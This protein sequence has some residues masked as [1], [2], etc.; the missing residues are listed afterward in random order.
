MHVCF[1]E[2]ARVDTCPKLFGIVGGLPMFDQLIESS[3]YRE[4]R[5]RSLVYVSLIIHLTILGILIV[6][7]LVYY[8]ALPMY[9][10][11]AKEEFLTA[12]VAPPLPK[13]EAFVRQQPV[14]VVK[15]DPAQF[16]APSEIPKEIPVPLDDI[17]EVSALNGIIGGNSEGIAGI[18]SGGIPAGLVWEG[19]SAPP[20]EAPVPVPQLT[21][22]KPIR[23]GGNV[24][25]SRLIHR[26]EPEYPELAKRTRVS[27]MVILEVIVS[28]AGTVEDV[29]VIRGHPL[30][31]EAA[32]RAVR[33]WKYSPYFL[34]GEPI[35]VTATV[36]V[37][38]VLR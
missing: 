22:K 36:T 24:Q 12:I 23:V 30:L 6:V 7:P 14:Q 1:T 3:T 9:R 26:V 16:V 37:K 33:Q 19:I 20:T 38:F 34:N 4:S 31:N 5:G 25:A 32:I 18:F 17:P 13:P 2:E 15:L 27:G 11:A 8:Q 28:E 21:K 35:P 10:W 29:T